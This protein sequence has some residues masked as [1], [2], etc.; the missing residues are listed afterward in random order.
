MNGFVIEAMLQSP[1]FIYR[2]ENQQGDGTAWPVGGYELAS[3]LSY[4]LWGGP[5]D[6]ELMR[7]AGAGELYDLHDDPHEMDNRFGDAALAPVQRR[8]RDMIESRPD[9]AC[10]PLPQVGMA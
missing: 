5:P 10:A 8:L 1:R 6:E 7:A 4:T 2:I 3:R 9:D